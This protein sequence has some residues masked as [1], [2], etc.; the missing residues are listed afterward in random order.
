MSFMK[1]RWSRFMHFAEKR[2]HDGYY[3]LM[4]QYTPNNILFQDALVLQRSRKEK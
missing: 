1:N 3:T 2:R 4:V